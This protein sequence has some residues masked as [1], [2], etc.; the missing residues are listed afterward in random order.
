MLGAQWQAFFIAAALMA[1]TPGANQLLSLRNA[2][3]QGFWD[4]STALAG[5][6]SAFLLLVAA[7][8]A[9]LGALLLAS[10]QAFAVVKWCGV[11]YLLYLG[12]RMLYNSRS[13]PAGESEHGMRKPSYHRLVH[14]SRWELTRQ[15]FL[16]AMTNPKATL[17]F[18][19][20]LPQFA[21]HS[22]GAV[23]FQIAALGV[24]Y[25]G[26]E[27]L[28][29]LVYAG[30]GGRLAAASMTAGMHRWF[31]RATGLTMIAIAGWLAF[32]QR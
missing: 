8:V 16:V 18:A 29:A 30:V 21:D 19:A 32:E 13:A 20:F 25:I 28:A 12:G 9:G 3:R 17:L 31:D 7:T 4:A 23:P 5:R 2:A 15:E 26:V 6:F 24:A 11:V 1:I 22:A 14:Q 27:F 10:E